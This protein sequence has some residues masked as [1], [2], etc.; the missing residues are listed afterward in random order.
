MS[1]P[2]DIR[3]TRLRIREFAPQDA[4]ALSDITADP[5]VV[6]Y[7]SFN[8]ASPAETRALLDFA[9]VSALATPRLEYILAAD[10]LASGR[11]AGSC[12]FHADT[13][14]N[15]RELYFV[16]RRDAWG[17]G[18]GTEIVVALIDFGFRELG[19]SRL[20]GVAHPDNAASIRVM[21]RAGMAYDGDVPE[22]FEDA[23]GWRT[24]RRYA[25][26]AP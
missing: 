10:E 26:L 17:R 15:E 6:R 3:T 12:G 1:H 25:I 8:A 19:L 21:E 16:L 18:L 7:L 20:F 23:G 2:V 22:A 11:L 5:D 14:A 24:G 4:I 9:L 13:S